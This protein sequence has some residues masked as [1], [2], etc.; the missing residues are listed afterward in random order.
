M[1]MEEEKELRSALGDERPM[2]LVIR[3]GTTGRKNP[4]KDVLGCSRLC[5][6]RRTSNG[7]EVVIV[8]RDT[9]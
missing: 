5:S 1:S 8:V 7:V 4:S 6:C 2:S 9:R 3:V